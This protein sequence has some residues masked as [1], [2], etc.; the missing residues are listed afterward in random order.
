M[1]RVGVIGSA[2]LSR[3]EVMQDDGNL[4]RGLRFPS[5]FRRDFVEESLNYVQAPDDILVVSYPKCGVHWLTHLLGLILNDFDSTEPAVYLEA[6]GDGGDLMSRK[7]RIVFTHMTS[8]LL[9]SVPNKL[10]KVI[11]LCRIPSDVVVSYHYHCSTLSTLYNEEPKTLQDFVSDF[12]NGKCCYGC[13]FEHIKGWL[14]ASHCEVLLLTYEQLQLEFADAVGRIL[15]F[16][17]KNDWFGDEREAKVCRLWEETKVSKT[18]QLITDQLKALINGTGAPR[19]ERERES[20]QL[21][22]LI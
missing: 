12:L 1:V 21:E 5:Y 3:A 8:E 7:P 19:G 13:Y 6:A 10:K 22:I 18:K 17:G 9:G 15:A 2:V 14:Q 16:I 20:R 11:Y 4:V